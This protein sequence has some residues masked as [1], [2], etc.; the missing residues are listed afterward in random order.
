MR[1]FSQVLAPGAATTALRD[2][3]Y[4]HGHGATRELLMMAAYAILGAF[5][6]LIVHAVRSRAK[7]AGA[8][9]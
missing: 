6:A 2:I 8:A 5:V 1:S 3:V 4:F 9:A 7:P